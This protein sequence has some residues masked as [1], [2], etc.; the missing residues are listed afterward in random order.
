[1]NQCSIFRANNHWTLR[2]SIERIARGHCGKWVLNSH[3]CWECHPGEDS[4]ILSQRRNKELKRISRSQANRSGREWSCWSTFQWMARS[5]G[6][7]HKKL[8]CSWMSYWCTARFSHRHQAS[9]QTLDQSQQ[10]W[11]TLVSWSIFVHRFRCSACFLKASK[12]LW[13]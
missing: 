4:R 11:A 9:R 13:H 7:Q 12:P 6:G 10:L 5:S 2:I 3:F 8:Q 1:V